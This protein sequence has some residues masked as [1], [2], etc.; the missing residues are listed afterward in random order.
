LGRSQNKELQGSDYVIGRVQIAPSNESG[1]YT[2]HS[3]NGGEKFDANHGE[4][5]VQNSN[6]IYDWV[7]SHT[8]QEVK[9]ALKIPLNVDQNCC[10]D[11]HHHHHH[12]HH[13]HK[14]F[15]YIG[16]F[17]LDNVAYVG[18]VYENQGLAF[19]DVKGR[20]RVVSSYQV[21]TCASHEKNGEVDDDDD[22]KCDEKC[23]D[24]EEFY[25]Q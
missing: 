11:D 24:E 5:L 20:R 25:F 19:V 9:N 7:K 6:D 8:G 12:H 14:K 2:S 22:W 23:L 15:A 16:R 10:H 1:V 17:Y 3:V 4:Y 21:L 18:S 13:G